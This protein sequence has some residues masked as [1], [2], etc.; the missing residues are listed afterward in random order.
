MQKI[1]ES[2]DLI[3]K[4]EETLPDE[5]RKV[6]SVQASAYKKAIEQKLK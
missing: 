3:K 2:N 4:S 5:V 1:A 6:S